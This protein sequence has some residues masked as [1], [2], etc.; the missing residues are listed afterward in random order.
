MFCRRKRGRMIDSRRDGKDGCMFP[1]PLY[2]HNII[3]NKRGW[4]CASRPSAMRKRSGCILYERIRR[5]EGEL[6]IGAGHFDQQHINAVQQ[7]HRFRDAAGKG[8]D[9][10]MRIHDGS[11]IGPVECDAAAFKPVIMKNFFRIDEPSLPSAG[12]CRQHFA[13][14]RACFFVCVDKLPSRIVHRNADL[15][16]CLRKKLQGKC[17]EQNNEKFHS[18][19]FFIRH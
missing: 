11:S 18:Y 4:N 12:V 5:N 1:P 13:V 8:A 9:K 19:S 14:I 17:G 16:D 15:V 7:G 3:R 2:N 6:R 10:L